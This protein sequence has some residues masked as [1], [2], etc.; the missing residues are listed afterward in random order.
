MFVMPFMSAKANAWRKMC[1]LSESHLI[2]LHFKRL[3]MNIYSWA[4]PSP[5]CCS[6][7]EPV[8]MCVWEREEG[9]TEAACASTRDLLHSRLALLSVHFSSLPFSPFSP[10]CMFFNFF[11]FFFSHLSVSAFFSLPSLTLSSYPFSFSS[12]AFRSCLARWRWH[13]KFWGAGAGSP[14]A[15]FS[16]PARSSVSGLPGPGSAL[17]RLVFQQ[18]IDNIGQNWV[19]ATCLLCIVVL[20]WTESLVL[21]AVNT[22]T[23]L[24]HSCNTPFTVKDP[25]QQKN[26]L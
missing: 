22:E 8:S 14:L 12:P 26:V 18:N 13:L 24:I 16:S 4:S 2:Y 1:W 7:G 15:S 23:P 5:L 19:S 20:V 10:Y 11:V 6:E 9:G 3:L 17:S 21:L 25:L